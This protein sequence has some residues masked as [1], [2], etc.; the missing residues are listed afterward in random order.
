MS[1][2]FKTPVWEST[3]SRGRSSMKK[4]CKHCPFWIHRF[5]EYVGQIS[6]VASILIKQGD[7]DAAKALNK[8]SH[9]D[10]RNVPQL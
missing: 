3:S 7:K 1:F 6:M 9:P 5:E 4:C 10:I 2:Q 8:A